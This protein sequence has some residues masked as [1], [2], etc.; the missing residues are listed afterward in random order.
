[1]D[2]A[3]D[4]LAFPR[5]CGLLAKSPTRL[6]Q[7]MHNAG[8]QNL[9]LPFTYV[10][11]D[12]EDTAAAIQA[13][14]KLGIRG[15]S[16]TIPHKEIAFSLVDDLSPEAK[17]IGAV[18]TVINT[19][20]RLLGENTDWLGVQ[21]ALKEGA[22]S[23][24]GRRVLMLGAGGA[25]RAGIYA[26]QRMGAKEIVISNRSFGRAQDL[27][28]EFSITALSLSDLAAQQASDF[29]LL[30]NST[31]VGSHLHPGENALAGFYN[32]KQGKEL[33][34]YFEMATFPT[35]LLEKVK[36]LGGKTVEGSRMLLFQA[37]AQFLLFTGQSAPLSAWK[38]PYSPSF[39]R[40]KTA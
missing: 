6:S 21:S 12:T 3:W 5:L 20:T 23:V 2:T 25:A 30:V 27:A 7:S 18:N 1:M 38:T 34:A 26:L 13:M 36:Q 35:P 8:F 40:N 24:Q 32:G 14:R 39:K 33:P 15:Y 28:A 22:V 19:G 11:F 16:L 4:L 17:A 37:E 10:A 31:P 9:G 29:S